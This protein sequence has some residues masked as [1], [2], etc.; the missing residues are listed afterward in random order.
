MEYN[1]EIVNQI[2]ELMPLSMRKKVFENINKGVS[3]KAQIPYSTVCD[4]LQ[5]Y[6]DGGRPRYRNR[7]LKV[8]NESVRLLA[9]KGI[10]IK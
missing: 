5:T 8:Y 7:R 2:R 6:R 4:V 9:E 10:T 1:Q 3:E